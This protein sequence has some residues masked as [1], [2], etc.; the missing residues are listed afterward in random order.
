MKQKVSV[1][2]TTHNL[3]NLSYLIEAISSIANQT[4]TNVETIIVVDHNVELYK[5]LLKKLPSIF[6]S[7]NLKIL[8][9]NRQKG[10]SPSR[11]LGVSHSSGD[12]ICFMDDD[13]MADKQWIS[14]VVK[15][16]KEYPDACG[17]GGPILPLG[18]IPW[19]MPRDF[20]WL[21]GITSNNHNNTVI[22]VRNTFGSNISFRKEVFRT[23]GLF[24]ENLGL[25]GA[26]LTQAEEVD[27]CLRCIRKMN[28]KILCNPRAIIYHRILP[29]RLK[30]KYLLKRAFN[31]GISKALLKIQY[32][33]WDILSVERK[34]LV[35]VLKNNL[36][37]LVTFPKNPKKLVHIILSTMFTITVGLGFAHKLVTSWR[38]T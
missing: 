16:Y 21:L 36:K 30:L 26:G 7:L 3:N 20:Y 13:A 33:S 9:N 5:H 17:V 28:C 34:Y 37:M 35:K 12:I 31:Q 38:K 15:T 1:I 8:F 10:L 19:W 14:E 27:F 32:R 25:K 11:N 24:N 18:K 2:I 22:E 29:Q 4:Y 23:V 6:P